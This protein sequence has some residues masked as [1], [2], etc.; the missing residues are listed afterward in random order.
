MI[1]KEGFTS[2]LRWGMKSIYVRAIWYRVL[3]VTRQAAMYARSSMA[4]TQ[5]QTP[6]QLCTSIH[7][8]LRGAL[9]PKRSA[10]AGSEAIAGVARRRTHWIKASAT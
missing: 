2:H 10:V 8:W 4:V 7:A 5:S 1:Y 9:M 3:R 6:Y